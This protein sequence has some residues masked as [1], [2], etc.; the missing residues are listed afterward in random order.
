MRKFI[1]SLIVASMSIAPACFYKI[2]DNILYACDDA[3]PVTLGTGQNQQVVYTTACQA[4]QYVS[5]VN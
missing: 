5:F 3:Y 1:L 2:E 4:I